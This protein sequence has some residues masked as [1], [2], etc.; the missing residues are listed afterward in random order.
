MSYQNYF[1]VTTTVNF[2]YFLLGRVIEKVTGTSYA[3]Y[4]NANIL[5][6]IGITDMQIG[7][8]SEAEKKP[9]EVVYYEEGNEPYSVNLSRMDAGAG[10]IASAT[11]LL[12]LIVSV[13]GLNL[14]KAILDSSSTRM[15]LTGSAANPGYARGLALTSNGNLLNWYHFG[16][17][18]GT[19]TLL[20]H[21]QMGYSWAILTNTGYQNEQTHSDLDQILWNAINDSTTRWPGKDLF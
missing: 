19:A 18:M 7:G 3:D 9:G 6:P 1:R 5:H 20:A 13:D 17:I 4:V 12:R 14:K 10:W 16:E 11:D 15:M 21:T 8:N 2:N